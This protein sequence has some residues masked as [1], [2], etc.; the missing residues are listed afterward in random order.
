MTTSKPPAAKMGAKASP[1][2]ERM[3]CETRVVDQAV[4]DLDC[5]F[6]VLQGVLVVR[7]FFSHSANRVISTDF[8]IDVH[9]I[10]IF[11]HDLVERVESDVVAEARQ[12]LDN[13]SVFGRQQIEGGDQ[14]CAGAAGR[15][16]DAQKRAELRRNRARG[17][18]LPLF[19]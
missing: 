11:G 3:L 16:D 13:P 15:I 7:G 4:A 17:R 9:A 5:R 14:E 2:V 18:V 10:K 12:V 6:E 8:G 1:P 19:P